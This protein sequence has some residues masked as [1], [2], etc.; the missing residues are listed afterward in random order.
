MK[1]NDVEDETEKPNKEI[2]TYELPVFLKKLSEIENFSAQ[3]DKKNSM[4]DYQPSVPI[5]IYRELAEELQTT[6]HKL[7]VLKQE[8]QQLAQQNIWLRE[9]TE[10]VIQGAENIR[11]ILNW[12]E[13]ARKRE[14]INQ[15]DQK[16][17]LKS[18][19]LLLRKNQILTYTQGSDLTAKP[20]KLGL[21][22]GWLLALG[23]I[24]II[25]TTLGMG[26]IMFQ[27][28]LNNSNNH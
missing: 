20:E 24:G 11:Q 21:V 12:Y 16:I 27:L 1:F 15:S 5:S 26:L 28:S 9:E 8:N 18:T 7:E 19:D 25:L 14:N 4:G 3:I 10:K 23:I 17:E 6:K 22:N 13:G 2:G